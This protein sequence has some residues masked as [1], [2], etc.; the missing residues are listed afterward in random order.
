[1]LFELDLEPLLEVPMPAHRT[2]SRQPS[3]RRDIALLLPRTTAASAVLDGLR[4]VAPGIVQEI[5]L[6]DLYQGKGIAD[7]EKSFAFRILM[8]DT[9][10]TLADA[11][12]DAAVHELVSYA[13]REF[14]ARLRA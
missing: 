14:G 3:V 4:S 2:L 8:Q 13:Q 5:A 7:T 11:E 1:M 12:V 10:R 6:F 9:E